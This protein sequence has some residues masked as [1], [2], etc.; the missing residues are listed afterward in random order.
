MNNTFEVKIIPENDL[1]RIQSVLKYKIQDPKAEALFDQIVE[2]AAQV[3]NVPISV[4]SFVSEDEVIIKA[5]VGLQIG[6]TLSRT[7]SPCSN[8]ILTDG[9]TI[10]NDCN[11]ADIPMAFYA[12]APIKCADGTMIG[13]VA[14]MDYKPTSISVAQKQVLQGFAKLVMEH[15]AV[16]EL[17]TTVNEE[18]AA[19]N[20]L[21][22]KAN[23][24]LADTQDTL[25]II[26][27]ELANS[28]ARFRGVF[29][30]AP[31]GMAV[32]VGASK[33]I[34][35]AN[36]NML[37][38]WS[39]TPAI[40]GLPH[41]KA[42]PEFNGQDFNELI[43]KVY[44]TGIAYKGHEQIVTNLQ[45][46]NKIK[47]YFNFVFEPIMDDRG[48]TSILVIADDVTAEVRARKLANRTAQM[49]NMAVDSA[50]LGTWFI[51]LETLEFIP[52]TQL[53][54]LFGL[55]ASEKMHYTVATEQIALEYRDSVIAAITLG[56][57]NGESYDLEFPITVAN[58][59]AIRWIRAT[60]NLYKQEKGRSPYFS[61]IVMDVTARKLTE[62]RKNDF[63]A[64]VSHELKTPL[65]SIKGYVQ[66]LISKANR[67]QDGYTVS[68]LNKVELQINKMNNLIKGFLDVARLEAGKINLNL[69]DFIIADL[70]KEVVA[71]AKELMSSHEVHFDACDEIMVR[72][73]KDKIAQVISNFISNAVKYSTRGKNIN[74]KC[75]QQQGMVQVSVQD[76][77]IGILPKD[78]D[79]LFNRFYRIE[80]VQT[81]SIS[82]FGIGLY[83]CA[84]II[85]RHNGNIWVESEPGMGSTFHFIIQQE[86]NG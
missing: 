7:S 65:T 86:F 64:M 26:I 66:L 40:I 55:D 60:G 14:I 69:E 42:I 29:E 54:A 78:V 71:E 85:K 2:L 43:N 68:A 81:R 61:G 59:E 24:E 38:I 28:E 32:L 30:R 23:E 35:F 57:K 6:Q 3:F 83:L 47:G 21:F 19:K 15:L 58:T 75:S 44:S 31:L 5:N 73:D 27:G 74:V 53:K 41:Y 79:K 1:Q 48:V 39:K 72:A 13:T 10:L 84:D 50:E 62:Q 46:G 12:A 51:D 56:V 77:G 22:V 25:K 9:V 76:E 49:L 16:R 36:D 4:I 11:F 18:L 8:T 70:I 67:S 63:I 52:S 80:N 45:N 37:K 17:L 34:E 20:R 33:I 82:G